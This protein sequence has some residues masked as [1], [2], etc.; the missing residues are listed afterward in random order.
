MILAYISNLNRKRTEREQKA[1]NNNT[2]H[3]FKQTNNKSRSL[4]VASSNKRTKFNILNGGKV[5]AYKGEYVT[6]QSI[7]AAFKAN[8]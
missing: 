2:K 6:E 4:Q 8:L 7:N 3:K 5:A 1:M